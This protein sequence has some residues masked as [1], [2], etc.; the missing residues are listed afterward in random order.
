[1]C[2]NFICGVFLAKRIASVTM[3]FLIFIK[4][5]EYLIYIKVA[6]LV[7]LNVR[8]PENLLA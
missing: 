1:M 4:L 3:L 2:S 8:E 5:K 6:S 7:A